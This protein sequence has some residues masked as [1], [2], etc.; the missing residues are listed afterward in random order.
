MLPNRLAAAA[1]AAVAATAR[2]QT[3]QAPATI[4]ACYVTARGT[5]YRIDTPASPAPG[6]AKPMVAKPLEIS[7]SPGRSTSQ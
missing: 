3:A 2:A 6:R 1:L 4:D 7:A 5:I